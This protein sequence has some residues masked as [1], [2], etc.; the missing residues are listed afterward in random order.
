MALVAPP[1]RNCY[2]AG[3][4]TK[5]PNGGRDLFLEAE[6]HLADLGWD[7]YLPINHKRSAECLDESRRLGDDYRDGP[8]YREL[9]KDFFRFIVCEAAAVFLIPNHVVSTSACLE[10]DVG[11][12]CGLSVC[13]YEFARSPEVTEAQALMEGVLEAG[14]EIER[15]HA[16]QHRPITGG[17]RP[18]LDEHPSLGDG[19]WP[20]KALPWTL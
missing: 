7:P 20:A 2:V 16:R 10:R 11:K 13:H 4:V 9:M 6:R 5:E 19:R 8:I 18:S 12:A 1:N 14:K 3:S 15:E 17:F